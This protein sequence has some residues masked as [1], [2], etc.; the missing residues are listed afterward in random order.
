MNAKIVP[1]VVWVTGAGRG[2]GKEIAKSFAQIGSKVVLTSRSSGEL[3]K[4]QKEIIDYG[5]EAHFFRCDISN[6]REV[7][8]VHQKILKKLGS[9]QILINNAGITSF[10]KFEST[11]VK[12][13]DTIIDVNLRGPFL[14]ISEVL[15][16][17]ISQRGGWI[18]NIGSVVAIKTFKKT[19]AYTAAKTGLIAMSD[20]LREEVRKYNIKVVNVLPGATATTIWSKDDLQK[21]SGRMMNPQSVAE[22]VLSVY[23]QGKRAVIEQVIIRSILGD[24]D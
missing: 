24:L 19:A 23:R 4:V 2:I 11:P 14:C 7:K 5:G 13:F 12:E 21:N 18:F 1:S 15:P 9:V 17:M 22:A 8:V 16:G 10:N 20:V 3:V 6:E